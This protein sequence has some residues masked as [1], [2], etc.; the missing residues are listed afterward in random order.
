LLASEVAVPWALEAA[1][2]LREEWGVSADVCS[3]TSW[4]ELRSDGLRA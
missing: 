4:T 3:V 2:L 1:D